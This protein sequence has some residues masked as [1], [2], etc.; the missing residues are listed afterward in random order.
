MLVAGGIESWEIVPRPVDASRVE[1]ADD[2]AVVS[3]ESEY[4]WEADRSISETTRGPGGAKALVEMADLSAEVRIALAAVDC[5]RTHQ[6]EFPGEPVE[7]DWDSEAWAIASRETAIGDAAG[8]RDGAWDLFR[9]T[10]HDAVGRLLGS[11]PA[12]RHHVT[13]TVKT[14]DG[15]RDA[16]GHETCHCNEA[17]CSGAE[18]YLGSYDPTEV[19]HDG[20]DFTATTDKGFA[21][22]LADGV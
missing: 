14:R 1:L 5:A 18:Q 20:E 17:G 16:Y 7:G 8:K 22:I 2:L 9:D 4:R 19:E 10:L 21:I 13:R 15:L 12:A 6:S 11:A 3:D